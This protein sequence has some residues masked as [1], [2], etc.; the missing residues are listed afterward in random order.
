VTPEDRLELSKKNDRLS[1]SLVGAQDSLSRMGADPNSFRDQFISTLTDLRNEFG[2]WATE[3]A[4]MFK[5]VF[6]SAVSSISSGITGLIM[7]TKTWGQ[8]LRDIGNT[9]LTTII[10][11]IVQMGVRWVLTQIMM[12]VAGKAIQATATATTTPIA[13]AQAAIWSVPAT[14]ATIASYGAAAVAAPGFIGLAEALVSTQSALGSFA[15]GGFTGAGGKY[16][17]AGVVHRGE[18][19]MSADSV[20]RIGLSNLEALHS[21]DTTAVS[22]SQT[23]I[24]IHI[25]SDENA[26]L[27]FI[28]QNEDAKHAIVD[29]VSKRVRLV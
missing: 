16:E 20:N 24:H 13:A 1:S 4:G 28:R 9:I 22:G 21:G 6:N 19:V 7:G 27:N 17:P 14:L 5:S 8:A 29:T 18:F 11:A 26:M 2:T 10:E 15:V 3:A 12:A 25:Q 23:P